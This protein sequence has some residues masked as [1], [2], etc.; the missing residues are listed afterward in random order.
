MI[1]ESK[2]VAASDILIRET[3]A[4]LVVHHQSIKKFLHKT[5]EGGVCNNSARL[6]LLINFRGTTESP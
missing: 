6:A 5:S 4:N 3:F 1:I 2:P